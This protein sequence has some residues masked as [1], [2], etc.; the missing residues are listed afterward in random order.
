M[1]DTSSYVKD[2]L[3]SVTPFVA[4]PD[5]AE[6]ID[7]Y[8]RIFGAVEVR[9]DADPTGIVRHA[10]LR[11]GDAPLE[12][13]QHGDVVRPAPPALPPVGVHL[14]VPD[15]DHIWARA[16]SA[17]ATGHPPVNQPYGDRE[18]MI[19]DPYGI[20]WYVATSQPAPKQP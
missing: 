7:L 1:A 19:V 20:T 11:F 6:A 2:G 8:A 15:V 14:Y 9:R 17:G 5:I 16:A 13:G 18:A 10:V 3:T 4:V 12:L